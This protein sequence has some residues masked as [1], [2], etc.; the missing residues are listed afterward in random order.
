MAV[1][2]SKWPNNIPT[3]SIR[4]PSKIYPNGIFWF[5]NKTSGNPDAIFRT[6]KSQEI[7]INIIRHR[8]I[9]NF[10]PRGKL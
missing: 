3:F 7:T 4:R 5:E 6:F 2:Y 1:I 10:A 9:L 8:P